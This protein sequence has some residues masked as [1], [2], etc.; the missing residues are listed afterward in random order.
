MLYIGTKFQKLYK[1]VS[2]MQTQTLKSKLGWSEF[3]K[4]HNSFKTLDGVMILNLCTSSDDA[5]HLYQV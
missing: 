4:G 1:R 3:T 5:F 2:E